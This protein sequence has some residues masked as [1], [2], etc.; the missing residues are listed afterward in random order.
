MRSCGFWTPTSWCPACFALWTT[1]A[2]YW[3][4]VNRSWRASIRSNHSPPGG[5]SA[6]PTRM[7]RQFGKAY[8]RPE[9]EIQRFFKETPMS[10]ARR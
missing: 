7:W 1:R 6:I 3:L 8:P 9:E 4:S 5:S 10:A 2:M